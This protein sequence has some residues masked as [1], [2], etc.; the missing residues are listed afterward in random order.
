MWAIWDFIHFVLARHSHKVR[1]MA[2]PPCSSEYFCP[3]PTNYNVFISWGGVFAYGPSFLKVLCLYMCAFSWKV[4][5]ERITLHV[6]T[7]QTWSQG[8]HNGTAR[9]QDNLRYGRPRGF[10]QF[11]GATHY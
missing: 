9:S 3:S 7:N 2:L 5:T 10:I 8:S 6:H 1:L 11:D 4:S